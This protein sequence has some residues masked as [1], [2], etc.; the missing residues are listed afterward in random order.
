MTRVHKPESDYEP[1]EEDEP[2]GT[3]IRREGQ[4]DETDV[5]TWTT[6]GTQLRYWTNL[7]PDSPKLAAAMVKASG[8]ADYTADDLPDGKMD[9]SYLLVQ[10]VELEDAHTSE[11]I[12]VPRVVL[13]DQYGKSCQFVSIGIMGSIKML[14]TLFGRG[15]WIPP[16][17]CK[18]VRGKTRSGFNIFRLELD[19]KGKIPTPKKM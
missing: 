1:R 19:E 11:L 4:S 14:I 5:T 12:K 13:M 9:V 6:S 18:L 15:P 2:Q 8:K 17:P 10:E 7:I 16:L 3:V